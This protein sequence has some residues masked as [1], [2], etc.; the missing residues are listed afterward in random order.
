MGDSCVDCGICGTCKIYTSKYVDAKE[1]YDWVKYKKLKAGICFY[2]KTLGAQKVLVIQSRGDRW[3]FPK[4]SMEDCDVGGSP[5]LD[6]ESLASIKSCALREVLEETGIRVDPK[7][8]VSKFVTDRTTYF[9]IDINKHPEYLTVIRDTRKS[10][11]VHN[12]DATGISWIKVSCLR[13][14]NTLVLN[15]H[16]KKILHYLF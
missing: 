8:L 3:G 12:N 4:G 5:T 16:C 15:S 13:K 11:D 14:L 1:K 9:L 6:P 7:H 10:D 2:D